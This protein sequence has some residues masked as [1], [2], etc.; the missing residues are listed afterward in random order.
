MPPLWPARAGE[1]DRSRAR[2]PKGFLPMT[3][4]RRPCDRRARPTA[5]YGMRVMTIDIELDAEATAL[6]LLPA[7]LSLQPQF[8]SAL[9][10][11]DLFAMEASLMIVPEAA[12]RAADDDA[13]EEEAADDDA[14][15]EED[16]EVEEE[17]EDDDDLD[18]DEDEDDDEDEEEDDL[19]N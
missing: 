16:E 3:S 17:E 9:N 6:D 19:D 11:L 15:E 13:E 12:K 10:P 5:F 4:P 1:I 18:E 7:V 8:S 2:C 14:E